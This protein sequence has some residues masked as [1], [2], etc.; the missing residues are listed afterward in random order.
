MSVHAWVVLTKEQF[1]NCK[2]ERL[3]DETTPDYWSK[4]KLG[5]A[6]L[7]KYPTADGAIEEAKTSIDDWKEEAPELAIC[8]LEFD[9]TTCINALNAVQHGDSM[10]PYFAICQEYF[11]YPP[12]V[13]AS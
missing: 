2:Q 7:N 10:G 6:W 5:N 11:W 12:K 9:D 8:R 1:E 3:P 13:G 4:L